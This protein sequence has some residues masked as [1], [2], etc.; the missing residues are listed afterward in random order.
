LGRGRRALWAAALLALGAG[1]AVAQPANDFFTNALT[2][3]GFS[4]T[5]TGSNV[6]AT[7]ELNEPLVIDPNGSIP[8]GASVWFRWV[9]PA[10]GTVFFNTLSPPP[11]LDTVLASYEGTNILTMIQRAANDDYIFIGGPSQIFWVA[12][13]GTEYRIKLAG[14]N[15]GPPV[16]VDMGPYSLTW[17]MVGV[18]TNQPPVPGGIQFEFDKYVV[19]EGAP[20]YATISVTY[21]GGAAGAVSV[22]YATA[23]GSA[24][25]GIHYIGRSGT[26]TFQFGESNKTFTIP[27][28]DNPD[29]NTNRTVNLSLSNPVGAILGP[30]NTAV[31]T[32]VDDETVPFIATSGRFEFSEALY[33]GTE[34]ESYIAGWNGSPF[35]SKYNVQGVVV[36]INRLGGSTGRVMVDY[37]TVDDPFFGGAVAGTDYWPTNGTLIFDDGQTSTNFVIGVG[38]DFFAGS[39]NKAVQLIISNP[40]PAPGENPAVIV[41]TLGALTNAVLQIFEVF[42]TPFVPP[43]IAAFAF[44]RRNFRG[45]EYGQGPFDPVT[46]DF[47]DTTNGVSWVEVEILLPSAGP[48]EVFLDLLPVYGHFPFVSGAPLEAG[49]DNADLIQGLNTLTIITP[50]V[51]TNTFIQPFPNTDYTDGS[52]VITN[53]PD[54]EPTLAGIFAVAGNL[55]VINPGR[56]RVTFPGGIQR[57]SVFLPLID[58]N[59]VEFNEDI[60]MRLTRIAGNPPV[61]PNAAF[62]TATILDDEEPSGAAD[63]MWNPDNVF[64]TTNRAYNLTPGA[65]N[66]V[67]SLAVDR[68]QK[69]VIVGDFTAYNANPRRGV[70]RI[71]IDGSLDLSFTPGTGANG[72]VTDVGIYGSLGTN[73]T[74]ALSDKIVIVGIFSSFNNEPRKGI[75]RLNPNGTLDG[76]F[77]P[78]A[79]VTLNGGPGIV[80]SLA[81]QSDGKVVI[82]G[83]FTHYDGIARQS[84]ARINA[85]GSLD[86][87]FDT[88]AGPNATVWTVALLETSPPI[89]T[90]AGTA[91]G[92]AED[93]N[94]IDTGGKQGTISVMANFYFVPDEMRIYYEGVRIF[95]TGLMGTPNGF[96]PFSTNF[97]V[98]FGP[99]QSTIV[100]IIMNE[101]SGLLGTVWDYTA[102]IQTVGEDKKMMIGGDFTSVNGVAINRIARLNANGALDLSFN[103]GGGVNGTVRAI[104]AQGDNRI[105]LG[106]SFDSVDFRSRSSIARLLPD[107]SL[108]TDYDPGSGFD[109]PV[110]TVLIDSSGKA[111]CGGPFKSFNGTRRVGMARLF[112]HAALDT[113]F[114]DTAHNQFAGL[115]HGLS[116][117]PRSFVNRFALQNDGNIMIGGSFTNIGCRHTIDQSETNAIP[118]V[119]ALFGGAFETLFEV[120]NWNRQEKRVRY[121]VARLIGGRT[122]GPGNAQFRDADYG[123]D[124]GTGNFTV[125]MSRV[126][127][128]LG[129]ISG[130]VATSNRTAQAGIDFTATRSTPTWPEDAYVAPYS[131]GYVEP[132]Y[133]IIP[134]TSDMLREGDEIFD[135]GLFNPVGS[136]FLGGEFIPLGGAI[137]RSHAPT[138]IADDDFDHGIIAFSKP[139]FTA[140]EDATNLT[141]T[142]VRTNGSS[143]LV[144][145]DYFFRNGTASGGVDFTNLPGR[146]TFTAIFGQ[147]ITSIDIQIPIFDD[148]VAEPDKT[149]FMVLTNVTGGAKLP[150]GQLTSDLTASLV[151]ID[152]D[153]ASGRL[154]FIQANFLTNEFSGAAIITVARIDGSV[155][156]LSA[157]VT[158]T[159]GTAIAGVDFVGITNRLSWVN[160]D[161]ADKHV[162]VPLIVDGLV[163]PNETVNLA[164]VNFST[165]SG[166]GFQTTATLTIGNDDAF[167]A[168]VFSQPIYDANENGTNVTII[169]NRVGGVA[170]TVSCTYRTEDGTAADGLDYVGTS[171]TLVFGPGEFSKSF[172]V[173]LLDNSVSDGDRVV[174][175]RITN[176]VLTAGGP[177]TVALL[178]IIDDESVNTPAGSLD[179]TL[180]PLAGANS[181]VYALSL[182]P[183]GK[184]LIGGDFRSV[185]HVTRNRMARLHPNG[186]LDPTFNAGLGPNRPVRAIAA[187]PDGRLLIGGFFDRVHGTNRAHIARLLADGSLDIFFDPGAGADNPVFSLALAPDG[188]VVAG[189]SFTT[190]DGDP[191]AGIVMLNTNGTVDASFNPGEGA[192]GT[193]YAVAIQGDGKVVLGG[194]FTIVG[195]TF[196]PGIAR[197]NRDGS[198]DLSFNL[199]EGP[200]GAVR[201]I[202]L[203]ADGGILLG[204]SFT[205]VDGHPRGGLAR[206]NPDGTVD[207]LFLPLTS[208]DGANGSVLDIE[209]QADG[210]LIVVGDF[211]TFNG[212]T[213][214]RITRLLPNGK[215]DPTINFGEGANSFIAAAV[216]QPDRRIVIGG[217]FTSVQGQTRN[218][219]A[220]LYGGSIAGPGSIEYSQ[221][222]YLVTENAGQATI[223]VRRKGGTTGEVNV[224][225]ATAPGTATA[226]LDYT[227]VT[228]SLFFPEGEVEQSFVVPL[229]N[230]IIIEPDETVLLS[231]ANLT[232]GATLGEVP[233]STLVIQSDD[234]LVGFSGPSYTVNENAIAGYASITVLRSGTTNSSVSI[235]Y[236]T[237]PGTATAPEDYTNVTDTLTFA[238]GETLKTFQVPIVNDALV[239]GSETVGLFLTNI[240]GASQLGISSATLVIV[241][242]D[243]SPGRIQFASPN[244]VVNEYETNAVIT[245]VRI[246]GTFGIVTVDYDTSPG[247]AQPVS[248][249]QPRSGQLTFADGVSVNTF[250]VPIVPDLDAET[251]ET[252]TLTLMSPGG[253]TL[254]TNAT[255]ILT[256]I[257]N[258]LTNGAFSFTATNYTATESNRS[259]TLAVARQFGTGGAVSVD[260]RTVSGTASNGLDFIAVTNTLFWANGDS[261]PKLITDIVLVDDALVEDPETFTVELF[262][263]TGGA[264]VGARGTTTVTILDEDVGPGFLGFSTGTYSVSENATNAL[265]TVTRLAGHTGIVAVD[266]ATAPGGSAVAG[267]DYAPGST[268]LV[269]LDGQRSN[270]FVVAVTNNLLVEGDK[271]ILL[272][273]SNPTGGASTNGRIV[274]ATLTILEDDQP[275]GSIDAGFGGSGADAPVNVVAVQT[276][277][278]KLFV[279]GEF[280]KFNG[281]DRSH[282]VRLNQ[283]GSVDFTFDPLT[284]LNNSVRALVVQPDGR[285]LVGGLFTNVANIGISYL[286]RL[287]TDGLLDQ[288]FL[289][290]LAG[291]DNVVDAIALQTD[292]RIVIGGGFTTVNG[293]SFSRIA[294]LEA[295]GALDPGFNP[296]TGANGDVHA[297]ALTA[298]GAILV[299]GDFSIFNGATAGGIVRLRPNG[300]IDPTFRTG[301]GFDDSVRAIVVQPGD[302]KI[303]VAGYFSGYSPTLTTFVPRAG[304][305]RLNVDGSLDAT[306]NPGSG[307]NEYIN[308]LALQPDGKILVGGGF[309]LFNGV[310]RSHLARLNS[311]GSIDFTFNIGSGADNYISTIALQTDRKIVIGGGFRH[312]DGAPRNFIAR[313]AGGDNVGS[314]QFAFSD[315]VYN[316]LENSTNATITVR[317]LVGS[318]N[319]VSVAF[320]TADGSAFASTHYVA[321]NGTLSFGPGETV[322]TFVLP[323]ID[324]IAT[325]ADRT[326]TLQLSNPTGGASLGLPAVATVNLIN[327]DSALLF[328][329]P[330]FSASESQG[331]N[332]VITVQRTGSQVGTVTVD[333]ATG[334]NGTATPGVDFFDQA[335]QLIFT[336]GQT[337]ASFLV[338]VIDDNIIEVNE[339]VS[340]QLFNQTRTYPAGNVSIDV[341]SAV[342]EIVDDDFGI[343]L[344]GFATS[345]FT[346]SERAGAATITVTRAGGS[347]GAASVFFA[348]SL[349]LTNAATPGLDY[350]NTNG[351]LVFGDGQTVKTFTVP[352][353]DDTL[354]EGPEQI[355]LNLFN[356]TGAALGLSS[357]TL[358]ILADEAVFSF[359]QPVFVVNENGGSALITVSRTPQGTG[360]VRVDFATSDNTAVNGLDYRGTNGTL[361]FAPGQ[362]T[363]FFQ[364]PIIDDIIG[365]GNEL[366]TLTLLNP[367]GESTLAGGTNVASL[368]IVDNDVSFSFLATNFAV[369]ET[370]GTVD[371]QVVRRGRTNG[372]DSV[373]FN[374]SDGTAVAGQDYAFTNLTLVFAPGE[375]LKTVSVIIR[376]DALG[377]GTEFLNLNL[378]NPSLGATVGD[379]GTATISI[380]DDEDTLSFGAAA[381]SVDESAGTAFVTVTRNGAFPFATVTVQFQTIAGTA[382]AGVDYTNVSG[383]LTFGFGETFKFIPIAITDDQLIEGDETFTVRLFNASG[384]TLISPSNAVV[385]IVENDTS[386]AFGAATFS[387]SETVANAV[388]P[389]V[390]SGG[391]AGT[392]SVQAFTTNGTATA[393]VDYVGTNVTIVFPPG[394]TSQSL[395]IRI[396]DDLLIEGNETVALRLVNPIGA[397]LGTPSTATLTILD[398]DASIIV[399]AGS[400][401]VSENFLPPSGVVD[402]GER[403][404]VNL[405]LRNI[406]NVD[407]LNLEATLLNSNGVTL[408]SGSQTFGVVAASGAV[409]SKPFTFTAA[410]TN[411]GRVTA[412]LRLQDGA[413]NLGTASFDFTLG[414]NVNNFI[415]S[416]GAA[417]NDRGPASPYPMTNIVSGLAGL[418]TKLTVT[419]ANISHT[420]PDDIDMLLVGPGGQKAV[421]MSDAGSSSSSANPIANLTIKFD[422][423]AATSIPD[424]NQIVSATYRPANWFGVGSADSFPGI[425]GPY[426][427]SS[428]SIFSNTPPNGVWSLYV[429]DDETGD[430]G[431]IA[432]GWTLGITT[433]E[434]I[435]PQADLSVTATDGPDP[436]AAGDTL[437]YTILVMNNGPSMATGVMLTNDL[438]PGM[439]FISVSTTL[440]TCAAVSNQVVCNLGSLGSGL[441]PAT[442]TVLGTPTLPGTIT[443]LASVSG[444]QL[445]VVPANNTFSI[446]TSVVPLT[447]AIA[448]AHEGNDCVLRWPAPAAGYT[449]QYA[450]SLRS[451]TWANYPVTPV[452]ANGMNSVIVSMT[453]NARYFRLRAP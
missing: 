217:G 410:G 113:S 313:L 122:P 385:T 159:S 47:F 275:A 368:V 231:L 42:G 65:N 5:V 386:V 336:N 76:S 249:Y 324:D 136:V 163:E 250:S 99:G 204:G 301:L 142:L 226:G 51:S 185:N 25:D 222:S 206:L 319:A 439:N 359:S 205:T 383:L 36:T 61:N 114:L 426:T 221:S 341:P 337:V 103:P 90:G 68:N 224:E 404:T 432:G 320:A 304:V 111:L 442:I 271:T 141:V 360:P 197:L 334:T 234:S 420:F 335:G 44:E 450:N 229:V 57:V 93:V 300:S 289:S 291:A 390:R 67:N 169:V 238:P 107:G 242:D 208:G 75:A 134:L 45:P 321:T 382:T 97:T 405:G 187:Q 397:V 406:G 78:G 438:P 108:D 245:V 166:I 361:V 345:N 82:A 394:V 230:D 228:A 17:V 22:D 123:A 282:V 62:A 233:D 121:N 104:G 244:F 400:A 145:V 127:G 119:G 248:D 148:V 330:R 58:D 175:L 2:I 81:L 267:L 176:F 309:T 138:T 346:V 318:S 347:A 274:A 188:Q 4:G 79:G 272:S 146:T 200:N 392:V 171:G 6:G 215:T 94:V 411:G 160:G 284:N 401:I 243:F 279:G 202:T 219:I 298:D 130:D 131:I 294:R 366:L 128:R 210:N 362:L 161:T 105:L 18:P 178:R 357:A 37:A 266:V 327:D 415:N 280:R 28:F 158:A 444:G 423:A 216:I 66:T 98:N 92:P 407:T 135:M 440:G 151:I 297:V 199:G 96:D 307:A 101:G 102:S 443:S 167:G 154:N 240:T 13:A 116:Q 254:G 184:I 190:F 371:I 333:F 26:L 39:G 433:T 247:T 21:G 109:G 314:G 211:T 283:S 110:F 144:T 259:V 315:A 33:A 3:A 388:I 363:A 256:I 310:E 125:T 373:E 120:H 170:G 331:S 20:G 403:V 449:L 88:G 389:V 236:L 50:N 253:A 437:T 399:P 139:V 157:D 246:G 352:I 447:L 132:Q 270:T 140:S 424:S 124:E 290:G 257:N 1:H 356:V 235:D 91:G 430:I 165:S 421:L 203:Q 293:L 32:I 133:F 16:G 452:V 14:F 220:R 156:P 100:T 328:T 30:V 316:V 417:I 251:N 7:L 214:R 391:T 325:N 434:S 384:A 355:R 342:L 380:F 418:I 19:S 207:P 262:N 308:A 375:V 69:T 264:I 311:N 95:D 189:G 446:K 277:N 278:N 59:V 276:N 150:G 162:I 302:N 377:E 193:V 299:G 268:N 436:L 172:Q 398:E 126:D 365:E 27:I 164:L 441:P 237:R 86:T 43:T 340:L 60:A 117:E 153:H 260:Y 448:I 53:F 223:T 227:N 312:F 413:N 367:G 225:A 265:I 201:A 149:F 273:L 168:L 174:T 212:V 63:R 155:G 46:G 395:V 137:G 147:G 317:R 414:L 303:L 192:N 281:E 129:T 182:Q 451:A 343:G 292:R 354:V 378:V 70:A 269:F 261:S 40:R 435:V 49:S 239:E 73:V 393:G 428:L 232:G 87:T 173:T 191:R 252:V 329:F 288:E 326:L 112:D 186:L 71:N 11:Q 350:I 296:G 41:P 115:I 34:W 15:N 379:P 56:I 180:A 396:N 118:R 177:V 74:S 416:G 196:R 344:I 8:N 419:V 353:F 422:D 285:L 55:T 306:F 429:V 35:T 287:G 181:P 431:N 241:D 198:L 369:V 427:N 364:V 358:T 453:N 72:P 23:D 80:R 54:V 349:G 348:L 9:A 351:L 48:A 12:Q 29:P 83:D 408:A 209:L 24:R 295:N 370:D 372:T 323:V 143:G 31:L 258:N 194:D 332:V 64:F 89:T 255:A 286:A 85:D 77:N 183:D 263:P 52:T 412:V 322:R 152:N 402:P 218:S 338:P 376:D 213:R 339:T 374:T 305:L 179:T 84:V 409:V 10:S 445:D 38:S 387:V 381:F 425:P 106:G 195:R